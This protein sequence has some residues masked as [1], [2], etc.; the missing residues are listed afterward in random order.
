[1]FSNISDAWKDSSVGGQKPPNRERRKRP[2]PE[3]VVSSV[4]DDTLSS[5][6]LA[7]DFVSDHS[8][9]NVS[10]DRFAPWMPD[11]EIPK[12]SRKSQCDYTY[13]HLKR[14]ENCHQKLKKMINKQIS[15]KFDELMLENR[16][17]QLNAAATVLQTGG[18]GTKIADSITS[19]KNPLDLSCIK[20]SFT[21]LI[22]ILAILV[23]L[24]AIK[25]FVR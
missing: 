5:I 23:V 21:I 22:V 17:Q 4:S 1:M 16:L 10:Y 9:N 11:P 3:K 14:C 2:K 6:T 18:S 15:K 7:D 19:N 8:L 24:V 12:Y 25:L 20:Q 13:T